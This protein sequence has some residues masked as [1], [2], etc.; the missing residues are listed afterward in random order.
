MCLPMGIGAASS[1][2]AGISALPYW[3]LGMTLQEYRGNSQINR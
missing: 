1:P 2:H 3:Q